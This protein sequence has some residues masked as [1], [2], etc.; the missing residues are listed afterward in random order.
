M[1]IELSQR[2]TAKF[3]SLR[4]SEDRQLKMVVNWAINIL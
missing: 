1:N 3:N 2:K 4:R